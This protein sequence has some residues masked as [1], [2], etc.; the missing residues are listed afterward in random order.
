MDGGKMTTKEWLSRA[1]TIDGE[2]ATLKKTERELTDKLTS[3]TQ[4]ITGDTVQDTK[5]P[6]KFD[7]LG[8]IGV[9]IEQAKKMLRRIKAETLAAI[10]RLDNGVY[11]RLLVLYYVNCYSWE[12]VAVEMNYTYRHT[13]R[14]HGRALIAMTEVLKRG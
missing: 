9:E 4:N 12:R 8:E 5:D 7:E 1:R 10:M 3:G 13:T 14:L 6:H 2:L 11:R